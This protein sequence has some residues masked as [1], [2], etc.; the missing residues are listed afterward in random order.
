MSPAAKIVITLAVSFV[1]I[2]AGTAGVA[3]LLWSRY[4]GDLAEASRKNIEQGMVFG[5]QT[6]QAG[7]LDE[8]LARYRAN[9]GMASSM[10]TSMFVQGCW[11]SSR[12]TPGFCDHVPHP[13]HV[14]R[15]ARW[16]KEQMRRMGL[17][18]DP[19]GG[20]IIGQLQAFCSS[21]PQ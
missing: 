13:F 4:S 6:D 15:S 1:V 19:M 2:A 10:A 12:S 9:R 17:D 18:G 5:K 16:Q 20:Q 14:L 7:C 8:A 3:V 11:R 21:R